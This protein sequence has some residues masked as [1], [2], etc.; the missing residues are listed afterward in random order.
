MVIRAGIAYADAYV[1]LRTPAFCLREVLFA[2]LLLKRNKG[3]LDLA[4]I[5]L[6]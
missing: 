2:T 5:T 3:G 1:G 6:H 4:H